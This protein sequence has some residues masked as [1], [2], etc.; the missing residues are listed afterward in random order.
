MRR[1]ILLLVTLAC[2][3]PAARSEP[4]LA[5]DDARVVDQG[6]CQ[7]E[8][9]GRRQRGGA[10][11]DLA[12]EFACNFTGNLELALGRGTIR[13]D[14][15][16]ETRSTLLQAKAILKPLEPNAAGVGL[17]FGVSR[18]RP[19]DGPR[20]SEPFV[21]LIGSVSVLDDRVTLHAN[22]GAVRDRREHLTRGTWGV[23]GEYSLGELLQ[24]VAETTGQR[25]EKPTVL[26]GLRL[27]LIPD[28]FQISIALGKQRSAPSDR[29]FAALG[30][31]FEF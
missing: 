9:L 11:R 18:A 22:L 10:E 27:R 2:V 1:L 4:P 5:T 7:I 8:G 12:L 25:G 13:S 15:D 20:F 26:A 6:K 16:G 28:Q 23:A 21:N 17:A 31:H 29:R 3:A 30:F 24:L 19:E 14:T